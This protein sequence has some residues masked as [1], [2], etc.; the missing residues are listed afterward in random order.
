MAIAR[1]PQ[2]YDLIG[3]GLTSLGYT[4]FD[5]YINDMFAEKYNAEQ[6]FEQMGFPLN[7]SLPIQ[8]TFEQ[9]EATIRPYTMAGYTDYDSDGPTKSTDG[10]ALKMGQIPIF[11]HE[12][13]VG[14]KILREQMYLADRIGSVTPEIAG[15]AMDQ[16]FYTV[17]NLLG[18]NYNTF[19][20]QRHQIVS[21][22][23]KLVINAKN[24]PLGIPV[25]IDFGVPMKNIKTEAWYTKDTDGKVTEKANINPIQTLKDIKYKAETVDYCP[26]GHFELSK[27]TWD[28]IRQLPT[29]VT[30]Y[31]AVRHT[32]VD[33]STRKILEGLVEEAAFKTWLESVLGAKIVVIDHLGIIERFDAKQKKMVYDSLPS[34]EEGVIVYVP[35]G[36]LGDSQFGK[37]IYMETPGARVS[38]FDGG[39]TML[40]QVFNDENM[41]QTIKSE[42][43]GL[44]VP[45]KTRWMYYLTVKG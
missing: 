43:Q 13:T 1:T 30:M 33:E 26:A 16:L 21:N 9:L 24:N 6:T 11:K 40:R 27:A 35:D 7:P 29:L 19:R 38:L 23:G 18:G 17:D 15:V 45:N 8:P 31:V 39:R 32:L 4:S 28:A 10:F 41:I 36:A 22:K 3:Q 42:V 20:Y 37:P 25:E 2:F 44:C 34:F 14:R 12:I 5:E